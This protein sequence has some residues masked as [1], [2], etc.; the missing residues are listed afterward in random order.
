MYF[1]VENLIGRYCEAVLRCDIELFAACWLEDAT[2][3]IPGNRIVAGREPIRA[4]FADI[5]PSYRLCV[6][7]IL[8][9]RIEPQGE[10]AAEATFQIRELQWRS[11]GSGSELIGV[12]HDEIVASPDGVAS[13]ARRDFELLYSGP[14]A[15]EGRLRSPRSGAG[16]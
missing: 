7:E 16:R 3:C 15:L 5:R 8:N 6:Q 1:A 14:V 10:R 13:F 12:Y 2:W 4:V 9:R 11:D